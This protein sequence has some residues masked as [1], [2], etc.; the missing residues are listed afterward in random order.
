M[1]RS[2]RRSCYWYVLEYEA[3]RRVAVSCLRFTNGFAD[4]FRRAELGRNCGDF[5]NALGGRAPF[6]YTSYD[7]IVIAYVPGMSSV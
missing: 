2:Q 5:R 1:V 6:N 7:A 3:L 4:H